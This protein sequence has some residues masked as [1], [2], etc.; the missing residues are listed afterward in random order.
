MGAKMKNTR[1]EKI[2]N[3]WGNVWAWTAIDANSKLIISY[4]VGQRAPSWA[5]AFVED[6]PPRIASRFQLTTD[7][8][9]MYA[10]AVEDAFGCESIA[11]CS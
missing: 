3:G 1:E 11:R 9:K 2:T 5:K 7:G 8:L 4:L 10:E 6:V